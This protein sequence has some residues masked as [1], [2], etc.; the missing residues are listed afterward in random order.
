MPKEEMVNRFDEKFV[1]VQF[2]AIRT[3]DAI[4]KAITKEE[5][6]ILYKEVKSLFDIIQ[7]FNNL[8]KIEF[9]NWFLHPCEC[10]DDD[11]DNEFKIINIEN[12]EADMQAALEVAKYN[13]PIEDVNSS[14]SKILDK[15]INDLYFDLCYYLDSQANSLD[16][17]DTD[18]EEFFIEFLNLFIGCGDFLIIDPCKGEEVIQNQKVYS[19]FRELV[20]K[21]NLI[22]KKDMI[23]IL[24]FAAIISLIAVIGI[25]YNQ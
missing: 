24:I 16:Y 22:D 8:E 14:Y 6:N 3:L 12:I 2:R 23:I 21:E 4:K 1:K 19:S 13:L 5:K 25:V 15:P 18:Y 7:N 17:I 10:D 20:E 11:N 9:Y